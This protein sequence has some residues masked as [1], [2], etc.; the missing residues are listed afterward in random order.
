M[1]THR[2]FPGA[3]RSTLLVLLPCLAHGGDY[4][5]IVNEVHYN[6]LGGDVAGALEFVELY[7]IGGSDVD[8]GG[9]SFTEGIDYTCPPGLVIRAKE[10]L[11][12]S[13]DPDAALRAYGLER[14]AGPCEGRLDNGGEIV[15]LRNA[16][17]ALVSRV[18]FEDDG[19]WPAL[20]DGLGPS[21]EFTGEDTGND[22][23]SRWAASAVLGGTPGARNSRYRAPAPPLEDT[24]ST[25]IPPDA[26][27]RTFKG[28][29]APSTPAGAWTAVGFDEASWP[30]LPGGFGYGSDH[31]FTYATE[32]D[33]MLGRYSTFYIRRAFDLSPSL[34]GELASGEKR[35]VLRIRYD[36]ACV[37]YLNGVEVTRDNVGTPGT[38]A[39]FDSTAD[40]SRAAE[41]TVRL[42]AFAGA[43]VAGRNVLA[44]QGL[45]N[46]IIGRDFY[47]GA[48]LE[49]E[50]GGAPPPPQEPL[51]LTRVLNEVRPGSGGTG[52]LELFNPGTEPLDLG[53]YSVR[54]GSGRS[55]RIPA[56]TVLAPS[57]LR[58]F[59]AA[60]LGFGPTAGDETY[61]LLEPD[62]ATVADAVRFAPSGGGNSAGRFPDGNEDTFVMTSPTPGAPNVYSFV[63]PVVL[64]E[65]HF[66]PPFVPPGGGCEARCSDARQWIELWNRSAS[67]VD[68]SGWSLSKGVSFD[69]PPGTSIPAGGALV[70][71][72]S[73]EAFRALHPGVANVVG[74]WSGR[75]SHASDTINLRDPLG[76]R[77]DHVRYGD[78]GPTNDEA[79]EDG[80]DDR[81][82]RGSAW[83]PGADGSGRTLELVHPELE[84]RS[85]LAWRAS[86]AA[87]GTPGAQSSVFD[88]TPGPVV[89]SVAHEPLVPRSS[90]GAVVTCRAWAV[91]A[92][93]SVEAR[94]GAGGAGLST[95]PLRDD[96]AAPDAAAGDGVWSG[97][98]PAQPDG[99][100]VRFQIQARD[101]AGGTLVVPPAPEVPPYNGF[102]G[103]FFLYETDDSSPPANGQPAYRIVMAARDLQ[104][105]DDR[106]VNSDV[107][108]PATFIGEGEVRYAAGVRYRGETSRREP[109]R[110]YR[111]DFPSEAL[112]DGAEHLN[113]NGS[114]GGGL[115]TSGVREV[116]AADLCRRAGAPYPQVYPVNL[117]FRGEVSRDFD[118]RYT[119]K[120]NL[121]DLF[122]ERYFGGSS[123]GNFYRARNPGGPG[124]ASGDLSYLGEDLA[125]Y[126]PLYDKKSNREE[127]DYS[128]LIGLTRALDP[129]ETPDAA[130]AGELEAWIDARQWA[131]FF[132]LQDL[133]TNV[134]GGI[135][136][137]NGEDY[138]LYR[139]PEGSSR[140]DAGR[141]LLV[142][143][144]MEETFTNAGGRLFEPVV[145]A[146]RRFLAHPRFARLYYEELAALRHGAF[147]RLE[148]RRRFG[149]VSGMYS[150]ADVFDVVDPLDTYVTD[151]I[152]YVDAAVYATILVVPVNETA[153]GT[154]VIAPGDAWRFFRGAAAPPGGAG[155]WTA[156]GYDDD[157]W[158]TGPTGI[159]YGD[160]DDATVLGDMQGSYTSLF[161][162]RR[163]DVPDPRAVTGLTLRIDY[164]DAFVAYVNGAEAARSGNAPGAAGDPVPFDA[165]ATATHE[166]GTAET[167]DLPASLLVAG[168]NVLAI[169]TLNERPESS[170]L[171]FVPSLFLSTETAG[172]AVAGGC[173]GPIYATGSEVTLAGLADPIT[174]LAVR[175]NAEPAAFAFV[176]SGRGPYGAYWQ[177]KLP[178]APGENRVRIAAHPDPAGLQAPVEVREV[179]V[180]RLAKPFTDLGGS[181][182]SD[183]TWTAAGGPYRLRADL[184]VPA[185]VTLSVEP[186]TVVLGEGGASIRVRGRIAA[187]GTAE[188]P[189][190]FGSMT[191]DPWGGIVLDGTGTQEGSPVQT[192]RRCVIEHG[193][194]DDGAAGVLNAVGSM[195]RVE[196][197][198]LRAL[199]SNALDATDALVE[200]RRSVFEDSYEGVH[201]TRSQTVILDSVFRRLIG[202]SDAIDFD[203]TSGGRSR[204]EGCTIEDGSDDGIDLSGA[205]VDVVGN[206][207]ARLSD[208]AVSLEGNGPAGPPLL[209]GNIVYAS[210]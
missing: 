207:L 50:G 79:P 30:E 137:N 112:F 14:V 150:P 2:R 192:L 159:G 88:A 60:E 165:R 32:L 133:L 149:F 156:R 64:S 173:D 166:A 40:G 68:L 96:G 182:P 9:W 167:F 204:I 195:L 55:F 47:I 31:G 104:E 103:P 124:Q 73:A 118:A 82:F 107:L 147:S 86:A 87:G 196:D 25:L 163:F 49:V 174:T 190:R 122:L 121:D 8:L 129:V 5:V 160:G 35:L 178:L 134:D 126:R 183:A 45:N 36:D 140:P 33:D 141:F 110:S 27:W 18:H 177:A 153:A 197:C 146:V 171:S 53:G 4:D 51:G 19:V 15:A 67:A 66:H 139:V 180:V 74:D 7:N 151:R 56:G 191:C 162:R 85:G 136:N 154:Q 164:D 119:R 175:V 22:L 157:A 117:R 115:A 199:S 168:T 13:P 113:L 10:H 26:R 83:P 20:A 106:D 152:G 161:A 78:G 70:V 80:A 76:N 209:R 99:T 43:L 65:I 179:L 29:S 169:V 184:M 12:F 58:L 54:L 202:D 135:W 90:E 203:A 193:T 102:E 98:I 17:G 39:A 72:G 46:F 3:A 148:M 185:G 210:G 37:A 116:L 143:W 128:D 131:Q 23:P 120:E 111:V 28:R 200:V 77:A 205:S 189:I 21:L 34:H 95:L 138:F 75:L 172:A 1:R 71:A 91:G 123:G 48:D 81:T 206:V 62:G 127:D 44:V 142:P 38:P 57:A 59:T 97:R 208:K 61:V 130:F 125:P 132:A 42:D 101:A 52:F 11:V 201:C 145:T 114:N 69:F 24:E 105:L 109:N 16:V 186:G 158:E 188:A 94:W 93:Q 6:P 155:A 176:T 181:L 100:V 108:L 63:S 41:T 194:A 89:D 144:D 187:L 92:V 84:N 170:D 198:V